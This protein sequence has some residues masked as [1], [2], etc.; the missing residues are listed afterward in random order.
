MGAAR[1][2][3]FVRGAA[4]IAARREGQERLD[5]GAGEGDDVPA[6]KL[7][8]CGGLR[9]G[10][11]GKTGKA[12]EIGLVE[13]QPPFALVMQD[14]LAKEGVQCRQALADRGHARLLVGAEP[15]PGPYEAQMM[16]FEHAH[17][18]L[19]QPELAAPRIEVGYPREQA[20]VE[21]DACLML[22]ELGRVIAGDRFERRVGVA[23]IEIGKDPAHPVEQPSAALDRLDRIGKGGWGRGG[24]DRRDLGDLLVHAAVKR[25]REVL[26]TDAIERRHAERRVPVGEKRV[27]GHSASSSARDDRHRI[28]C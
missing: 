21:R 4:Q 20:R 28:I 23:R 5:R 19:R 9:C 22:G 24:D 14:V 12:V 15:R 10:S 26:G 7:A 18:V 2:P 13:H 6:R 3:R 27:L 8:L 16:A 17:L 11:A 1:G 25:R